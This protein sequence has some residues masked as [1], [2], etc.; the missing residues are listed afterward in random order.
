LNEASQAKEGIEPSVFPQ[1]LP[2]YTGHY[3]KPHVVKGTR[4]EYV[5]SPYQVSAGECDQT[6]R[7]LVLD[8]RWQVRIRIHRAEDCLVYALNSHLSN[9]KFLYRTPR[10]RI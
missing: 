6:K 9:Y 8:K 3:H 10:M 4:I 2:V 5:G 1:D 7:F